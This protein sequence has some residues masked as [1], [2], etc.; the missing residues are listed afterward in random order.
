M[1]LKTLLF[2]GLVLTLGACATQPN[3]PPS[4]S[5]PAGLNTA[6]LSGE[7]AR[8]AALTGEQ[9]RRELAALENE[10]RLDDGRRFLLAALLEREDSVD[11]LERSLKT[12]GA[13][14]EVDARTQA[15]LELM[16]KSLRA[17]IELR[18][19][20]LRAQELQDKLDQIKALEKSLQQRA[21]PPRTP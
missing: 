18:Q 13:I 11:A 5:T 4:R 19:Q 16:K 3:Q 9:R 15:L 8:V 12:L 2:A 21:T 10:R 20:T 7:L 6:A 1:N 17:R 14:G